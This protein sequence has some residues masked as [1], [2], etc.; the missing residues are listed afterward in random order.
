LPSPIGIR[1]PD[2]P[3]EIPVHNT[4]IQF[5]A[6][7]GL[8]LDKQQLST[9]PAWVGPSFQSMIQSAMQP[10][11][12][13][14]PRLADGGQASSDKEWDCLTSPKKLA[15]PKKV[16]VMR[17]SLSA[18]S[19]RAAGVPTANAVVASYEPHGGW[20]ECSPSRAAEVVGVWPLA[21]GQDLSTTQAGDDDVAEDDDAESREEL[22]VPLG[23]LPSVGSLKHAEGQCKRCCFFPK[24]RCLNGHSCEFCH[25]DH[26]KRKRKKKKKKK[27][28]QKEDSDSDAGSDSN[29]GG[30]ES[31]AAIDAVAS[32]SAERRRGS[33]ASRAAVQGEAVIA[34][35]GS[36]GTPLGGIGA[37]AFSEDSPAEVWSSTPPSAHGSV[38]TI[39]GTLSLESPLHQRSQFGSSLAGQ[40]VLPAL[41]ERA[42]PRDDGDGGL[43]EHGSQSGPSGQVTGAQAWHHSVYEV[44]PYFGYAAAQA[45]SMDGYSIAGYGRGLVGA[46]AGASPGADGQDP[47][48]PMYS[49]FAGVPGYAAGGLQ[50]QVGAGQPWAATPGFGTRPAPR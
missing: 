30:E 40:L 47:R 2:V 26:E 38:G 16:P 44:D 6:P 21:G 5:G 45:G 46:A 14:L 13:E 19:A 29:E 10:A 25:F 50:Q 17:Y 32:S 27:S 42:S 12:P 9:A 15:S 1:A 35:T 4:F 20:T 24:G 33:G 41:G 36:A 18:S 31:G 48:L 3:E 11:Q 37:A 49:A 8:E 34:A 28:E 7:K 39:A 22:A 43:G 23:E